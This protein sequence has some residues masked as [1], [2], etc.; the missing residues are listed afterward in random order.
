MAITT[1]AELQTAILTWSGKSTALF[2]QAQ[3]QEFISLAEVEIND[4]LRTLDME[5]RATGATVA[6][7]PRMAVPDNFGG[8]RRMW[9]SG[10]TGRVLRQVTSTYID[11]KYANAANAK[12]VVYTVEGSEFRF[13]PTPDSAYSLEIT[14]F[15]EVPALSDSNTTNWLLTSHPNVYRF[16]V[17][18]EAWDFAMD[19]QRMASAEARFGQAIERLQNA[20]KFNKY[21]GPLSMK[22][23]YTV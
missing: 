4:L 23:D 12:P 10:D 5:T 7:E 17:M 19:E 9:I 2:S 3:R 6:G 13:G 18:K 15:K 21:A 22:H 14:Y 8:A 16:A 11:W 1:Y 20:D